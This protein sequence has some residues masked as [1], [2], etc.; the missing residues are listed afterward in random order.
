MPVSIDTICLYA[1]YLSNTMKAPQTVQNYVNGVRVLHV[2]HDKSIDA[3]HCPDL[4]LTLR[5]VSRIKLHQPK[6]AQPITLEMLFAMAKHVDKTKC[7]E[8]VAWAAILTAFFCLLRK[9]NYV[10]D[11]EFDPRKQLCR[12]DISVGDSCMLVTIKWSKTIQ[13][14]QRALKIPVLAIPGSPIC[15]VLAYTLMSRK[16]KAGPKDPA[17]CTPKGKRFAP[18][19]YTTLQSILKNL[20]HKAGWVATAFSSHS[21]RR[22]GASLAFKAK[23][24]GELIQIQGDWASNA[25]LRYL[26]IPLQQRIQVATQ[27]RDMVTSKGREGGQ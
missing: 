24:P 5:G 4:K 10:V 7:I 14:A 25:Y 2:L 16:V 21:L 8:V 1:Q 13:F 23:V 12:E 20:V 27:V 18:L 3:F 19:K 15:P 22:G 26:S 9:S 11:T 17:F 6:Q